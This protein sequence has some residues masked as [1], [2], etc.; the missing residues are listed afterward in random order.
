[1]INIIIII[2]NN[3]KFF[4]YK[5]AYTKKQFKANLSPD[6]AERVPEPNFSPEVKSLSHSKT[7]NTRVNELVNWTIEI[8]VDSALHS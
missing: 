3:S 8:F 2:I 5:S 6:M 4:Y 1:M 7:R